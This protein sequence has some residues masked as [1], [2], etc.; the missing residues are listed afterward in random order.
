[1]AKTMLQIIAALLVVASAAA[2]QT[3]DPSRAPASA[4]ANDS[5]V[6]V[7]GDQIDATAKEI[8][9]VTKGT[10]FRM[11]DV[12]DAYVGVAIQHRL[13]VA[14]GGRLPGPILHTNVSEVYYVLS[15]SATMATG[16]VMT[17]QKARRA[18]SEEGTGPGFDGTVA[19]P[20]DVRKIKAG[21]MVIIPRNMAHW[22][23]EVP[24][25]VTY[26]VVRIDPEKSTGLK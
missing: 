4:P 13:K 1:M 9:G 24:E 12:G 14:P 2:G 8:Q 7:T 21:D 17:D 10:A 22:F 3:A 16:G 26:I 6:Y 15:G 5:A 20:N 18:G 11:V 19:K 25:D 23:T